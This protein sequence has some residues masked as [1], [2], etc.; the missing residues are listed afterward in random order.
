[1]AVVSA[2]LFHNSQ[3]LPLPS[4]HSPNSFHRTLLSRV[5]RH[6]DQ[7]G[8]AVPTRGVREALVRS[9]TCS[10]NHLENHARNGLACV[11]GAETDVSDVLGISRSHLSRINA[12][13]TFNR[14]NHAT[15][16]PLGFGCD[17]SPAFLLHPP[18]PSGQVQSHLE[19]GGGVDTRRKH[20][21]VDK[22][23][24][25][26][27][28]FEVL[29]ASVCLRPQLMGPKSQRRTATG[30]VNLARVFGAAFQPRVCFRHIHAQNTQPCN[31]TTTQPCLAW[32]TETKEGYL[33]KL[34]NFRKVGKPCHSVHAQA[35]SHGA[36]CCL[37]YHGAVQGRH[38]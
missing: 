32:Q 13:H 34:G 11:C 33:T 36:C 37:S 30:S 3:T 20:K 22:D 26:D 27:K 28:G 29:K 21:R 6:T 25:K 1:M 35:W 4:Q 19:W 31:H 16:W 17:R 23:K 18:L 7:P 5:C 2:L 10:N 8:H 24:D 14:S 15:P 12:W 9:G 38:L